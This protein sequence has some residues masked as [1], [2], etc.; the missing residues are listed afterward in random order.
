MGSTGVTA[1][2]AQIKKRKKLIAAAVG[3]GEHPGRVARHCRTRTVDEHCFR[4]PGRDRA[5]VRLGHLM[6]REQS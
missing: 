1:A 4:R 5:R 3:A 2:P 6:G